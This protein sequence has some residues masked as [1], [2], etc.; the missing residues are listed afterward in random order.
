MAIANLTPRR[1]PVVGY[2]RFYEIDSD[3]NFF[4]LQRDFIDASGRHRVLTAKKRSSRPHS[5]DYVMVVL[6]DGQSI[7]TVGLHRIVCMAFHGLP[8]AQRPHVNHKNGVTSDNRAEN[9]EWVSRSENITHAF[10]VLKRKSAFTGKFGQDNP[11]SIPVVGIDKS[12]VVA[13]RFSGLNEAQ[14]HG[15]SAG[16]IS[17]CISG[18]RRV[19]KGLKWHF[20]SQAN[21]QSPPSSFA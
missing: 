11:G 8:T 9:L 13:V 16:N 4:S 17:M 21:P 2:E 12:G 14:R 3:G 20:E 15:Y 6:R 18:K 1:V 7:K 5:N 19:H 10:R